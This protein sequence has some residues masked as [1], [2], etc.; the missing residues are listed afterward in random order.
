MTG[1]EAEI[2]TID[3]A[4]AALWLE[5]GEHIV[6]FR[7]HNRAFI[8]G[9]IISVTAALVF[10]AIIVYRRSKGFRLTSQ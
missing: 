2:V 10:L 7:Y 9:S 5:A 6:E 8:L 3:G 1:S 4:M